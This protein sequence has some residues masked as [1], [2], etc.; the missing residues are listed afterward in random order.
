M[1]EKL[2]QRVNLSR[3]MYSRV[4][5]RTAALLGTAMILQTRSLMASP[6]PS[7]HRVQVVRY[8]DR[9]FAPA[10]VEVAAGK[11]FFLRIVNGSTEPIEFESFKLHREKVVAPGETVVVQ[12]PALKPG[13][14]DF[15]D[16]FHET[17]P[18]GKIVVVGAATEGSR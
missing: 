3:N 12:L 8:A 6:Q 5:S 2:T 11:P 9:R 4:L 10:T 17:V 14:Y 15:F 7:P 16:D 13:N 1:I 18:E